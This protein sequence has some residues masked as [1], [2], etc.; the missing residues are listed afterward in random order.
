MS[1]FI[2][3]CTNKESPEAPPGLW[4]LDY[5]KGFSNNSSF[6]GSPVTFY[7]FGAQDRVGE[8]DACLLLSERRAVVNKMWLRIPGPCFCLRSF[9]RQINKWKEDEQS[10]GSGIDTFTPPG[11]ISSSVCP[12][13]ARS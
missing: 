5:K 8:K 11:L 1:L 3:I 10:R 4:C 7:H 6:L 2:A 9:P 12:P 13:S